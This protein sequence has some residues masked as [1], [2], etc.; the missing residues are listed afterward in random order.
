MSDRGPLDPD[1]DPFRNIPLFGD[2]ARMLQQQGP[3]SWDA[4]RQLAASIATDGV[5]EPNIDPLDRI[6]LEQLARVADLQVANASGLTTSP[7]GR[8]ITV[9]PVNRGQWIQQSLTSYRPLLEALASSLSG[10]MAAGMASGLAGDADDEYSDDPMAKMLGG[11]M[12]AFTPVMLGM[13]AGSMLGHLAKRSFGQYD[14][15]IPRAAGDELT[16]VLANLD[17]FGREWSLPE[18]DL[19]LWVC[20]HEVAHHAVLSLPHVRMRMD[21]LLNEYVAG[22]QPDSGTLE[23]K[24]GELDV[25]DMSSLDNMQQ[26]LGDP[27]CCWARSSHPRSGSC[28]L[29]SKASWRSSSGTSITS[30][31]RS[32]RASSGR[33]TWSRKRCAV[34]A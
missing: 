18:D 30:W 19:R 14:L 5:S 20:V 33:T 8:G 11:I 12:Q 16:I 15:P 9:V 31:T 2:L 27:R 22:F 34:A 23:S 28:S 4:A 3:V 6:K 1:N 25:T 7:S 13:T 10:G 24:L 32:A 26:L 17:E 21:A 29:G